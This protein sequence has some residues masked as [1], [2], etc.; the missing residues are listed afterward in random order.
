[1]RENEE[2][3]SI[4]RTCYSRFHSLH[5]ELTSRLNKMTVDM[6]SLHQLEV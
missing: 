5:L 3:R 6:G 2:V 1:M 4:L